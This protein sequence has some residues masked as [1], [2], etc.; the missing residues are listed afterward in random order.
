MVTR[1]SS[2]FVITE[3]HL[4][5]KFVGSSVVVGCLAARVTEESTTKSVH[6]DDDDDNGQQTVP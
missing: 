3:N 4:L 2:S 1:P 6:N 5:A